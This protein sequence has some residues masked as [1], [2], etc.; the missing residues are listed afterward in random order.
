MKEIKHLNKFFCFHAFQ[1]IS[2]RR[3]YSHPKLVRMQK[4]TDF[5]VVY[6]VRMQKKTNF[7]VVYRIA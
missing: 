4:E 6:F 7:Y 2:F 1:S 3:T 5:Y